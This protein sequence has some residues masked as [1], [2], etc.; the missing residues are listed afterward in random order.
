[1][2][3]IIKTNII[4]FIIGIIISACITTYAINSNSIDYTPSNENWNVSTV[5]EAIND[6]YLHSSLALKPELLWTNPNPTSNFG[7]QTISLDL[8]EYKYIIVTDKSRTDWNR[9]PRSSVIVPVGNFSMYIMMGNT[10][11]GVEKTVRGIK[12]TPT[13]VIFTAAYW[14]G[15]SPYTNYNIPLK[16]YGIRGDMGID[17]FEPED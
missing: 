7:A 11:T 2:K 6:L 17:I 13:G 10:D 15:D 5:E 16:I 3:K 4:S 9:F 12:A 14:G 1:M 8:S